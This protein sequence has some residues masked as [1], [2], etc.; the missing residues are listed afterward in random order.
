[1]SS[2][3]VASS[4]STV[5]SVVDPKDYIEFIDKVLMETPATNMT[6]VFPS[7]E[8]TIKVAA[9][10]DPTSKIYV[11]SPVATSPTLESEL[12]ANLKR[13]EQIR[14]KQYQRSSKHVVFGTDEEERARAKNIFQQDASAPPSILSYDFP[15][16]HTGSPRENVRENNNYHEHALAASE[17]F[18]RSDVAPTVDQFSVPVADVTKYA[19]SLPVRR[20]LEGMALRQINHTGGSFTY[21]TSIKP[22]QSLANFPGPSSSIVEKERF[23]K[24][25]KQL[26]MTLQN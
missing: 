20:P 24:D 23:L 9:A 18:N 5:P 21:S 8:V 13:P 12:P 7:A 4:N 14:A 16:N 22:Q 26:R 10:A 19:S 6:K 2:L 17:R 1:M 11:A 15:N 25:L 3:P